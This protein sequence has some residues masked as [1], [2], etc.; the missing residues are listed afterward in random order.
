MHGS[1]TGSCRPCWL[2]EQAP[3]SE[4][5]EETAKDDFLARVLAGVNAPISFL[6]KR[7][8][9]VARHG[10]YFFKFNVSSAIV[11]PIPIATQ[12]FRDGTAP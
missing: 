12:D 7:D 11:T 1:T 9:Y 3:A 2:L 10:V 5:E 8:P 4:N 6:G